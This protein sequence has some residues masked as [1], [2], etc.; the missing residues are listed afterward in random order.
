MTDGLIVVNGPIGSYI[1]MLGHQGVALLEK[2]QGCGFVVVGVTCWRKCASGSGF[3]GFQKPKPVSV[4][5]FLLPVNPDA[6]VLAIPPAPCAC[7]L[8]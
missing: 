4:S 8:P 3:L 6:E 7:M 2:D 5:L 1:R